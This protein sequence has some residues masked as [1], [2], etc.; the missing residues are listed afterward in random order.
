MGTP[1]VDPDGLDPPIPPSGPPC[2]I[3]VPRKIHIEVPED[4]QDVQFRYDSVVVNPP[5]PE[6]VFRQPVPAGLQRVRVDCE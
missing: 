2:V 4:D 6:G 5:L 3:E 1:R